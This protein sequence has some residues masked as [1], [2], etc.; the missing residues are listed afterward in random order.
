M[1]PLLSFWIKV[2]P[3]TSS[4]GT[5]TWK[6][7][8]Q[9][10]AIASSSG[11]DTT[12]HRTTTTSS[13]AFDYLK[14]AT[15]SLASS[16]LRASSSWM[17]NPVICRMQDAPILRPPTNTSTAICEGFQRYATRKVDTRVDAKRL[18]KNGIEAP[19]PLQQSQKI[20]Q[21]HDYINYKIL[22]APIVRRNSKDWV[23]EYKKER[24]DKINYNNVFGSMAEA[25]NNEIPT[26]PPPTAVEMEGSV[27]CGKSRGRN[28]SNYII[29]PQP[30]SPTSSTIVPDGVVSSIPPSNPPTT[31]SHKTVDNTTFEGVAPNDVICGRG[32]KANTHPGNIS[33]REEAKKLRSWYESS[34]KSEKF[35]IS[36]FLVDVVRE[37]GGRFL[38]RDPDRMGGWLEADRVEVRKKASQALREGR[39]SQ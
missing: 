32:G 24:I 4:F 21:H 7:V 12:V 15:S 33:F 8:S 22:P 27:S 3:L 20:L 6:A 29:Q 31:I 30:D 25:S 39:R 14:G 19:T 2:Q 28:S 34:S 23:R 1:N 16:I 38:K 11:D 35:T 9:S 37:R 5:H 36:S 10:S 17:L 13:W 26:L 18:T